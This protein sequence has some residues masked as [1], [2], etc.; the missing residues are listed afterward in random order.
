[1]SKTIVCQNGDWFVNNAGRFTWT[2]S[3]RHKVAQ[4]IAN[5][6]LQL[7]DPENQTGSFLPV[8]A[9]KRTSL[10]TPNQHRMQ[11]HNEVSDAINRLIAKQEQDDYVTQDEKI[12]SF[13]VLVTEAKQAL[14]YNY[15][16]TVTTEAEDEP[17]YQAYEVQLRHKEDPVL[18]AE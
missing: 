16:L 3:G 10:G 2:E 8:L 14:S 18:N 9:N 13:S 11:L 5:S 6:L 17:L 4:D 12:A 1:M 7:Y 15:L